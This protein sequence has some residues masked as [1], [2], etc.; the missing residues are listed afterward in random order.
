MTKQKKINLIIFS[1]FIAFI[2]LISG[3]AKKSDEKQN[4]K[5]GFTADLTG[6]M[7][8][9]GIQGRNGALL[10]ANLIN[11]AGGIKGRKI[12]IVIKNDWNSSDSALI[13]DS[14]FIDEGINIVIGHMVSGMMEKNMDFINSNNMLM[15]SPTVSTHFLSNKQDNFIALS[16]SNI[17]EAELT[18]DFFKS[19]KKINVAVIYELTNKMFTETYYKHFEKDFAVK[20]GCIQ[21][22]ISYKLE[23]NIDFK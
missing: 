19:R 3:C 16:I 1:L 23:N 14:E 5:I 7:S 2:F 6:R 13:A 4:I 22:A 8:E 12:E 20:G 21:N 17:P 11:S 9:L 15:I 10:A 18:S